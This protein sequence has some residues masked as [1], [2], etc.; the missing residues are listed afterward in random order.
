VSFASFRVVVV[1]GIGIG[2]VWP[3]AASGSTPTAPRTLTVAADGIG[4]IHFGLTQSTAV[5]KLT[6][7]LGPPTTRGVVDEPGNCTIDGALHWSAVTAYFFH[8][9]FVG[10]SSGRQ[11]SRPSVTSAKGLRSGDTLTQV[12]RLYGS[13]LRT[14]FAQGGS[15]F[16]ATPQGTMDGILTNEVNSTKPPPRVATID[17]G[18]V[19]C[20]AVS[21]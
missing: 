1:A 19:G 2:L 18:S 10:F 12:R 8:G 15:W 6:R 14:S 7:V 16:V 9:R 13:A 11:A 3:S 4:A 20:P 17:A 5:A 21:P